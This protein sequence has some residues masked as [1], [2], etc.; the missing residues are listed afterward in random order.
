MQKANTLGKEV[1]KVSERLQYLIWKQDNKGLSHDEVIELM[2]L[3]EV[4]PC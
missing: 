1:V 3:M 4:E 2:D